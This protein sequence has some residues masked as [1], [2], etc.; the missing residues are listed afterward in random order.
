MHFLRHLIRNAAIMAAFLLGV[1]ATN[2]AAALAF[3]WGGPLTGLAVYFFAVVVFISAITSL[4][5]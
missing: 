2:L 1:A 5:E 3:L 4:T